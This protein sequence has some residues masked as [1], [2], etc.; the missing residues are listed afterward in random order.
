MTDIQLNDVAA[1][2]TAEAEAQA[3]VTAV[4]CWIADSELN[5]FTFCSSAFEAWFDLWHEEARAGV[6]TLTPQA[7]LACLHPDDRNRLML[8]LDSANAEQMVDMVCRILTARNETAFVQLQVFLLCD[9]SGEARQRFGIVTPA[10]ANE[11]AEDKGSRALKRLRASVWPKPVL[12]WLC[13]ASLQLTYVSP[14]Y[15]EQFGWTAQQAEGR[16]AMQW[17]SLQ[18]RDY[19]QQRLE[20][21]IR[22]PRSS[23]SERLRMQ[24]V[25]GDWHWVECQWSNLLHVP[26]VGALLCQIQDISSVKSVEDEMMSLTVRLE[27]RTHAGDQA[28]L[29]AHRQLHQLAERHRLLMDALPDVVLLIDAQGNVIEAEGDLNLLGQPQANLLGCT[30]LDVF[31]AT[32][33]ET[34]LKAI[35]RFEHSG[36]HE[37]VEIEH[38]TNDKAVIL[39][40]RFARCDSG[41]L[42]VVL[43]DATQVQHAIRSAEHAARVDPLTGLPNRLAFERALQDAMQAST[44]NGLVSCAVLLVDLDRFKQINDELG[45]AVGDQ[46]L[47]VLGARL[48]TL[49]SAQLRLAR[50]GGDEFAAVVTHTGNP[51]AAARAAASAAE[52]II[53]MVA[54][55]FLIG[56]ENL[57][58]SASIGIAVHPEHGSDAAL[59]RAADVAMYHAKSRGRARYAFYATRLASREMDR[60][61][62]EVTLRRMMEANRLGS[63]YEP[64]VRL[65]SGEVVGYELRL[66]SRDLPNVESHRFLRVAEQAGMLRELTQWALQD[67]FAYLRTQAATDRLPVALDLSPY[68]L[69][70]NVFVDALLALLEKNTDLLAHLRLD[71]SAQFPES[72][73][74]ALIVSTRRLHELSVQLALDEVGGCTHLGLLRLPGLTEIKLLSS[75]T[76]GLSQDDETQGI[77]DGLIALGRRLGLRVTAIGIASPGTAQLLAMSGIE[78]GQG[79]AFA[80]RRILRAAKPAS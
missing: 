23:V 8:A 75:L 13:D 20:A 22:E 50:I 69:L 73:I 29:R 12:T 52:H 37:E 79:S 60:L 78:Y 40:A 77:V 31:D 4:A 5:A 36:K 34:L 80:T 47:M 74:G 48:R 30:V 42:L 6:P 10:S 72:D 49:D 41:A 14:G 59:V 55:P 71:I 38:H 21:L 56:G 57:R 43:R 68:L 7:F 24:D 15:T 11:S 64:Q 54:Q 67:I 1:V 25:Q 44:H 2:P 45:H 65:E 32:S 46:V 18:D 19:L 9:A 3:G 76:S 26:D 35:E 63:A 58:L 61:R 53:D 28:L 33:A 51:A 27:Q 70:D 39:Q 66:T 16:P 62:D 17:F